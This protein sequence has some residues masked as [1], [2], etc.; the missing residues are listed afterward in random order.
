[1]KNKW[2]LSYSK[3]RIDNELEGRVKLSGK[4]L[5]KVAERY[6][7]FRKDWRPFLPETK[8]FMKQKCAPKRSAFL[9]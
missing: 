6:E 2:L 8:I 4:N 5:K 7:K 3:Y 1:T 9:T